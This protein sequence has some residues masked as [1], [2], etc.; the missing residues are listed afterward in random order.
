MFRDKLQVP[1]SYKYNMFKQRVLDMSLK[2]I[3]DSTDIYVTYSEIKQPVRGGQKVV[4][5][6]FQ[7]KEKEC[8]TYLVEQEGAEMVIDYLRSKDVTSI[9]QKQTVSIYRAAQRSKLTDRKI[10]NRID[11]VLEK[12]NIKNMV[13]YLVFAMSE[14]FETPKEVRTE[15]HNFEQR[16]YSEEWFALLEKSLLNKE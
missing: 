12:K 4:G 3:N 11:V 14:N 6:T 5:L 10:K 1:K 9:T 13:G 2:E 16:H 7:I 15:F 8:V